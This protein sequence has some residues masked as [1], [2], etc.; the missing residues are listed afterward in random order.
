[1][2]Y[3][4]HY[5]L[6]RPGAGLTRDGAFCPMTR[7]AVVSWESRAGRRGDGVATRRDQRALRS[8]RLG[9]RVRAA[10]RR[11]VRAW[12][13]RRGFAHAPGAPAKVKRLIRAGNRIAKKPYRY[14]GGHGRRN[15]SGYDCSGG[16]S[17]TCSTTPAC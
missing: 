8:G 2:T 1:M 17:A 13:S 5:Y 15:D 7:A 16:R 11:R 3:A 14:G 9:H 12:I 4:R 6:N 10:P